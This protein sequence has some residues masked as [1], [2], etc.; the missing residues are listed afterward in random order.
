VLPPMTP[1]QVARR[2]LL[3]DRYRAQRDAARLAAIAGKAG[4][5]LCGG[6]LWLSRADLLTMRGAPSCVR[7]RSRMFVVPEVAA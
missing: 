5:L 2:R 6:E 1:E 3:D 7:C 4:C